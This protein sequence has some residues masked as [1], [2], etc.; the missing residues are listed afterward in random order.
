M[1]VSVEYKNLNNR[2]KSVQYLLAPSKIILVNRFLANK[3]TAKSLIITKFLMR[4]L[5]NDKILID[6]Y[7]SIIN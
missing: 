2:K 7:F 1:D 3:K 5:Y 6:S 4:L